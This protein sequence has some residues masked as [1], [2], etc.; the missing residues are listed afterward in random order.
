MIEAD[1]FDKFV[2]GDFSKIIGPTDPQ[3]V[4]NLNLKIPSSNPF[5]TSNLDTNEG[6]NER[7][8]IIKD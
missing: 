6:C 4:E 7:N 3:I 2:S 8:K 5:S 1:P